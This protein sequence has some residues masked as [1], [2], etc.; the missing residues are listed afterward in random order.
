MKWTIDRKSRYYFLFFWI[1]KDMSKQNALSLE[2][3]SV[4]E[5]DLYIIGKKRDFSDFKNIV[6]KIAFLFEESSWG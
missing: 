6:L 4:S 2:E 1:K 5:Q 3:T